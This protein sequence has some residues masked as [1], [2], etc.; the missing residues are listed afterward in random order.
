MQ[1]HASESTLALLNAPLQVFD[2]NLMQSQ[3]DNVIY[4]VMLHTSKCTWTFLR[5]HNFY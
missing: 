5:V 4:C 3:L 2:P 1:E